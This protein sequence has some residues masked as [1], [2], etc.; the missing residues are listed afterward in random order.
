MSFVLIIIPR[1]HSR[2]YIK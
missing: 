2:L 1:Y